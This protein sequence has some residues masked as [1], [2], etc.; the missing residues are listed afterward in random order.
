MLEG[1]REKRSEWDIKED[2]SAMKRVREIVLDK[3]RVKDIQE[4]IK[5][6]ESLEDSIEDGDIAKAL[7]LS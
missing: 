3:E 2:I 7:G 4:F 6:K 1:K 5:D